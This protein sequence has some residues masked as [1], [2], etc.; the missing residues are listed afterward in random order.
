MNGLTACCDLLENLYLCGSNN[1]AEL[2]TLDD[3]EL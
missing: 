2:K 1:N 3:Y